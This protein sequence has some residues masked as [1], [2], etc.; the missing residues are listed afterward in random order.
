M[1]RACCPAVTTTGA[2]LRN[3]VNRLPSEWPVPA[4]LC[5]LTSAGLP[6][7]RAKPSAIPTTT[8]SFRPST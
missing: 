4:A 3:A 2:Q 1:L 7:D 5:R 8:A 6:L